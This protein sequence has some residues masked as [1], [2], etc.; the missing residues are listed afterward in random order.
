MNGREPLLEHR[1]SSKIT[2]RI[3]EMTPR[4]GGAALLKTGIL[5]A[6]SIGRSGRWALVAAIVPLLGCSVYDASLLS[7]VSSQITAGSGTSTGAGSSSDVGS[8]VGGV[9]GS[10]A[11]RLHWLIVRFFHSMSNKWVGVAL[12]TLRDMSPIGR[13]PS[14]PQVSLVHARQ[15]RRA[16]VRQIH[17]PCGP[18]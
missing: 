11:A 9:S 14:A 16:R 17:L 4:A 3:S 15:P 5:S 1:L 18:R 13:T 7:N 8:G 6:S 12:A 10:P 2:S